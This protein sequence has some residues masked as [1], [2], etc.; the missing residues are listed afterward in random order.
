M[1]TDSPYIPVRVLTTFCPPPPHT[2]TFRLC[3]TCVR[4]CM[5]GSLNTA[6]CTCDCDEEKTGMG[7]GFCEQ[8]TIRCAYGGY[9]VVD[10]SKGE[11]GPWTASCVCPKDGVTKKP[12]ATGRRCERCERKCQNGGVVD[13]ESCTCQCPKS[14]R[15]EN[16]E[17]CTMKAS[18]CQN[19]GKF[20]AN[21]CQCECPKDKFRGYDCGVPICFSGMKIGFQYDYKCKSYLSPSWYSPSHAAHIT[22][23]GSHTVLCPTRAVIKCLVPN[24]FTHSLHSLAHLN[25]YDR[26]KTNHKEDC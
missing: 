14:H 19:G 6:M 22:L 2:H 9:P 11:R 3:A 26:G 17:T 21:K 12:I 7:G 18:D 4:T 1:K 8:P 5:A 10:K 23:C 13:V 15:G 25:S 16:C 20:L 24:A